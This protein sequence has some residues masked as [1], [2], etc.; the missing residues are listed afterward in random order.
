MHWL[1]NDTNPP[2]LDLAVL[3]NITVDSLVETVVKALDGGPMS[4]S[5]DAV[6]ALVFATPFAILICVSFLRKCRRVLC[7]KGYCC[8]FWFNCTGCCMH[9][10]G[11]E[12][13]IGGTEPATG[14]QPDE[15]INDPD[16]I[17]GDDG[18]VYTDPPM[19]SESAPN[20]TASEISDD[21]ESC[22]A[23]ATNSYH[24]DLKQ[25]CETVAAV[26]EEKE[27]HSPAREVVLKTKQ[28]RGK[29]R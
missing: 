24:E 29:N 5:S 6:S 15:E 19:P 26:L 1:I 18:A 7:C 27:L 2:S 25:C 13:L 20:S 23:S 9:N 28:K 12:R 16:Q 21:D 11:G 3:S 14:L 8:Y 22:A 17:I 4:V 10:C